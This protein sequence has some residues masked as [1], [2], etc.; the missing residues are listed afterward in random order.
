MQS[1]MLRATTLSSSVARS[2]SALVPRALS[3]ASPLRAS[4]TRGF[5]SVPS[6]HAHKAATHSPSMVSLQTPIHRLAL[7]VQSLTIILLLAEQVPVEVYP[8]LGIVTAAVSYGLYVGYT[9][10]R[11]DRVSPLPYHDHSLGSLPSL[12]T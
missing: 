4:R 9:H 2:R 5:A 1:T 8:L 6:E 11:Y 7:L 3:R 12:L 10:M